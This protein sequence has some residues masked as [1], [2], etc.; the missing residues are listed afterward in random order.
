MI[1]RTDV[2]FRRDV[3]RCTTPVCGHVVGV[4]PAP[5]HLLTDRCTGVTWWRGCAAWLA[6]HCA[7]HGCTP[8]QT[9]GRGSDT[10]CRCPSDEPVALV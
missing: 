2:L 3:P 8:V 10:A 9:W 6:G 4:F 5:R 1:V 7:C